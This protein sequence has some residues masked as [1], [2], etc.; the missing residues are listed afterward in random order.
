MKQEMSKQ[1]KTNTKDENKQLPTKGNKMQ[2]G[3]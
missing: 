2:Q 3:R 1:N